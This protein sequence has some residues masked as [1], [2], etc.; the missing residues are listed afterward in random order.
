MTEPELRTSSWSYHPAFL[1]LLGVAVSTIVFVTLGA[2]TDH[3]RYR[4]TNDVIAMHSRHADGRY[5]GSREPELFG[6]VPG[7]SN[8]SALAMLHEGDLDIM[9]D[10]LASLGVTDAQLRDALILQIDKLEKQSK[11]TNQE[12]DALRVHVTR[13]LS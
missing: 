12:A 2:I 4:R 1:V 5:M 10:A 3:H 8:A 11:L 9:H 6:R 13:E 7:R